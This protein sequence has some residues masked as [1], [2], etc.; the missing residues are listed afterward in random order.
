MRGCTRK[1]LIGYG[2]DLK[3]KKLQGNVMLQL[4]TGKEVKRDYF[5]PLSYCPL[6]ATLHHSLH[7]KKLATCTALI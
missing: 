5:S 7:L 1:V 3:K 6:Q 4:P 2:Q